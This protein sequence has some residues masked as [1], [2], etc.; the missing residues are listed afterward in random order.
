MS[1]Y[2][3]IITFTSGLGPV[4]AQG[5][6][7]S[8]EIRSEERSI[9]PP[10]RSLLRVSH[11]V[12]NNG[13]SQN[14]QSTPCCSVLLKLS[15]FDRRFCGPCTCGPTLTVVTLAIM[16]GTSGWAQ[17][18]GLAM[19]PLFPSGLAEVPGEHYAMLDGRRASFACSESSDIE[20]E[21]SRNWQWSADLAHH[22]VIT[23]SEVQVRS[24]HDP[25]IRKF[26]RDSV[27]SRIEEFLTFLNAR[28]SALPD[29]VSFLVEEFKGIW[30]AS[31]SPDGQA[32]FVAFL[33]ALCAAGESD[34]D[35]LDD[36]V[37]RHKT[38]LDI[39]IDDPD[40]ADAGLS[41]STIARARGMQARAPLGLRLIPSLVL[42]HAAGRLFQEAHAILESVQPSFFGDSSIITAPTF[43]AA[44]AYF[45][46]VPIARLL[47]EW[48]LP[49]APSNPGEL[50]IA[51][52][53]C[54]SAVFLTEALRTLEGR[55][56]QGTVHLIGRDKSAQAI[57]MA[58]VAVRTAER[59]LP[60]MKID[61]DIR[62]AD[63]LDAIW[64][65]ADIV[66]MNP[67]F[68]SW[69]RMTRAEQEWVREVTNGLGSGRLD[70]SVGFVERA[71]RALNPSGILA[72]LVPAGVLASERLSKWRDGMIKR[73][74][75]TLV[76]VLGEHGLF[77]HAIV[78]VGILALKKDI[79][80]NVPQLNTH[81][82]VAWSSAETGAASHAIRAIRR[83]IS[84]LNEPELLRNDVAGWSVT[85]T[86]LAAWK[87]RPSW[88][89]GAGALGPLLDAIETRTLTK[90]SDIFHVRQGIRT[91]ANHVFLQPR[92]IV[93]TLPE[94]EQI[95]FK[96]AVD[97]T[98][99]ID[100]EIKPQ[101]YLFVPDPK[102]QTEEEL[103]QAVPDFFN[104]YLRP[105][106]ESLGHR[107]FLRENRWWEL[108]RARSRTYEGH[109]RL[110]SKRFGLYPAFARDLNGTFAIVQANAW[111]PTE[112]LIRGRAPDALL[113]VLTAYWWLLNSRMAIALLREYCPN[114]AG[115]QLDLEHKYVKHAP[116]PNL[117]LQFLENPALQALATSIRTRYRDRLPGLADRDQFTAAAFGTDVSE[118]NVSGLELSD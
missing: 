53:A 92:H 98:S 75:P 43:S 33:L 44:G 108:A 50:T 21:V 97:T 89:P 18:L 25:L 38:A 48:A 52:F 80:I 114:V 117:P 66:L 82:Y 84:G 42:R 74:T 51:D 17:R 101:N 91:G 57:R 83:S 118:W 86:S 65:K 73:A 23:P 26:R 71:I 37:W 45:T 16:N 40:L 3:R 111:T 109:P 15:S 55:A 12:P 13:A 77:E 19:T 72:T 95:F 29:V 32:A 105:S 76:A 54:G 2:V 59:D 4:R 93:K 94:K 8:H 34:T 9:R 36:M 85:R 79:S 56:F 70:L 46:P 90:V 20:P 5:R 35:T 24:G 1:C 110:V 11:E 87:Q 113:E 58:K 27:D 96:E 68:R 60:M 88:L 99:F 64:P 116:L 81:L 7:S 115:G 112:T 103:N 14:F 49:R 63:A 100:G 107:K 47:A 39:G 6:H 61:A 28:R 10:E 102:W 106:R 41:D 31:G 78:N 30:A 104:R 22:V 62:Q 67:P 69:E